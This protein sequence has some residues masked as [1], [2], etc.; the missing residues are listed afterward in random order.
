M[1]WPALGHD[2]APAGPAALAAW[3]ARIRIDLSTSRMSVGM[4]CPGS[5][6][7]AHTSS[8]AL[9]VKGPPKTER[10]AH[11]AFSAGVH[12]SW[13]HP[14]ASRSVRCLAPCPLASNASRWSRRLA[15]SATGSARSRIAASSMASG[16]PSSLRH[17]LITWGR[18]SGV[19]A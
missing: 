16:R 4:T 1:G 6:S 10:H 7:P 3:P 15:S 9:M 18:S 2:E 14:I 17:S 5:R 19:N 11:S 8:A 13:L 12:R